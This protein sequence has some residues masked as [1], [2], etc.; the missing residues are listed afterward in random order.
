MLTKFVNV[1]YNCGENGNI[2]N[3]S[4]SISNINILPQTCSEISGSVKLYIADLWMNWAI[5][6]HSFSFR[7]GSS[8]PHHIILGSVSIFQC[9]E[10]SALQHLCIPSITPKICQK[11]IKIGSDIYGY[12]DFNCL[13]NSTNHQ[14][15]LLVYSCVR[16]WMGWNVFTAMMRGNWYKKHYSSLTS[17]GSKEGAPGVPTYGPKLSQLHAVFVK[18]CMLAHLSGGLAPL[19]RGILDP[20][21]LTFH[22]WW[23]NVGE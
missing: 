5:H 12:S 18:L 1:I 8:P 13:G 9:D 16:Y 17:G 7:S 10:P 2:L 23:I 11:S 3:I 20:P 4:T 14:L 19:L 22:V 15:Y 6:E 21:L